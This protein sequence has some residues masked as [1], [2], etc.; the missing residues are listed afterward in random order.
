MRLIASILAVLAA[1]PVLAGITVTAPPPARHLAPGESVAIAWSD[2]PAGVEELEVLL[3]LDGGRSYPVRLTPSMDP[4]RAVFEWV[5]PNLPAACARVRLRVGIGGREIESEASPPFE[6]GRAVDAP[7]AP[8]EFRNGEWWIEEADTP[9][10]PV[11]SLRTGAEP[12]LVDFRPPVPMWTGPSTAS[13]RASRAA[14]LSPG[15]GRAAARP[16]EA[17]DRSSAPRT[18]PQR[19]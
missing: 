5:V 2:L 1:A 15:T 6:I 17:S 12:S 18:I 8:L 4:R 13:P 10:L 11:R 3:S 16:E 7:I 14:G 19:R 9:E